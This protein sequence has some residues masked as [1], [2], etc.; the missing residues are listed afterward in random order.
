[1]AVAKHVAIGVASAINPFTATGALVLDNTGDND[2][3]P[4]VAALDGGRGAGPSGNDCGCSDA[5]APMDRILP[6]RASRALVR[7]LW[8]ISTT[9]QIHCLEAPNGETMTNARYETQ[10][11]TASERPQLATERATRSGGIVFARGPR[12]ASPR[13]AT[14]RP[15]ASP[16]AV[17]RSFH[18]VGRDRITESLVPQQCADRNHRRDG[19]GRRR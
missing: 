19:G 14:A 9:G 13:K 16:T 10:P 7:R 2:K 3:N 11:E 5:V 17:G 12:H 18:K 4:S 1:M 8:C 6:V 15:A